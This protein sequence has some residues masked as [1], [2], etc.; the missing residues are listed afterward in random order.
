MTLLR[1]DLCSTWADVRWSVEILS[2]PWDGGIDQVVG[3]ALDI[4][5]CI[6]ERDLCVV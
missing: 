5:V 4:R 3:E 2:T 6:Y 1:D